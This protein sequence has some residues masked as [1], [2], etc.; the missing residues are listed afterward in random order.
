ML[1]P[2]A[3][4]KA[5]CEKEATPSHRSHTAAATPFTTTKEN[6]EADAPFSPAA[7]AAPTTSLTS[8]NH[9]SAVNDSG[10]GVLF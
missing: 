7:I 3:A 10:D 9:S 4:P 5:A 2:K 8:I 6:K 1:S